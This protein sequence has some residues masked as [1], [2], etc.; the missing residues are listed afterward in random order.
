MK[1][2]GKYK[3]TLRQTIMK[4]QPSKI[5]GYSKSSSK[6]EVHRETGLPQK[7]KKKRRQTRK[8]EISNNLSHHLKELEKEEQT[9]PKVSRRK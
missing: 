2:K 6:R 3:N 5:Y 1:S 4:T 7:K 9:K 8:R